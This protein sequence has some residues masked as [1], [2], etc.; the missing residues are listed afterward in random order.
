LSFLAITAALAIVIAFLLPASRQVILPPGYPDAHNLVMLAGPYYDNGVSAERA[1]DILD[2]YPTVSVEQFLSLKNSTEKN[3]TDGQLTGLAFYLP[4]HLQAGQST[5]YIARTS[6]ELFRLLNIPIPPARD[7]AASLVLTR[8]AWRKY[9]NGDP[10]IVGRQVQIAGQ[11]ALV[12]QIL[13]PDRWTLP[14][15][16][17]GWLIESETAQ[18]AQPAYARGFALA[19]LSHAARTGNIG[20]EPF[21][22]I[23]LPARTGRPLFRSLLFEIFFGCLLAPITTSLSSLGDYPRRMPRR[24]LF[25]AAKSALVLP[26]VIFGALDLTNIGSLPGPSA[27]MLAFPGA[28]LAMRWILADQRRRC[29]VCLRHLANPVRIGHSSRMLL[30]WYGTE[31]MCLRGHGLLHIPERPSIWFSAQRWMDLGPSWSG[32]FP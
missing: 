28:A 16:V 31:L 23:A 21:N 3:R 9:F 12:T 24:W 11:R 30:E 8:T 4:A 7:H 2:P 10:R 27:L 5:L 32:L 13:S 14:A 18:A 22:Y 25:L 26:I 15:R 1:N 29:P 17:D 6:A 19:R 20:P